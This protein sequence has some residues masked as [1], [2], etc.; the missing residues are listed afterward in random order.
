[1]SNKRNRFSSHNETNNSECSNI[2]DNK[3]TRETEINVQQPSQERRTL[4]FA[5]PRSD[6]TEELNYNR[7]ED[8][9]FHSGNQRRGYGTQKNQNAARVYTPPRARGSG[10]GR[11]CQWTRF[12]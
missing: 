1:M 4:N 6:S 11:G 12:R 10:R 2:I 5:P 3:N 8:F 9:S 7:V